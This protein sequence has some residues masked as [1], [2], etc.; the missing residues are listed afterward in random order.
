M[1]AQLANE[2]RVQ[3]GPISGNLNEAPF[4]KDIWKA[5]SVEYWGKIKEFEDWVTESNKCA[6]NRSLSTATELED[7]QIHQMF[8]MAKDTHYYKCPTA[9]YN[10]G[11]II[12]FG[13]IRKSRHVFAIPL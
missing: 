6:Q 2:S 10:S 8:I 11:T 9:R 12:V 13:N 7:F 4:Q 5:K 3:E 1:F